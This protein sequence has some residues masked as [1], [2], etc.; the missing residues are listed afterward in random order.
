MVQAIVA[1]FVLY[2]DDFDGRYSEENAVLASRILSPIKTVTAGVMLTLADIGE[3]PAIYKMLLS[4][5]LVW[6]IT[7]GITG[8]IMHYFSPL[9]KKLIQNKKVAQT[10][11]L[12]KSLV[13]DLSTYFL[14]VDISEP[15]S[16]S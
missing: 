11:K 6:L 4:A 3:L 8:I 9:R 16:K 15:D 14:N 2:V 5:F 13:E 7:S 10:T 1:M 12:E